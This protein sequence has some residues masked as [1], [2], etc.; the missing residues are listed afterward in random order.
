M[1]TLSRLDGVAFAINCDLIERID[2]LPE[3]MLTLV[4]GTSYLVAE[5]LEDVIQRIQMS[6]A[7][8][9]ALSHSLDHAE[10]DLAPVPA[11]RI[12]APYEDR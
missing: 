9:V 3:T 5:S 10:Q 12:V 7:S 11:L 1:I 6:R 8:I 2:C 4:D